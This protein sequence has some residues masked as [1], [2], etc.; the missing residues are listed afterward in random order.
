M[1]PVAHSGFL[2]TPDQTPPQ[3]DLH[4]Q[5]DPSVLS[6]M[7]VTNPVGFDGR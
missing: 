1:R 4:L 3:T 2:V 7:Q 5:S 6:V